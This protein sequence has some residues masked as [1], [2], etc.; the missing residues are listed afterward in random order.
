MNLKLNKQLTSADTKIKDSR[1][2]KDF[3]LPQ[4]KRATS[5]NDSQYWLVVCL[6]NLA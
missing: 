4:S 6:I 5:S 2:F 3:R 1:N